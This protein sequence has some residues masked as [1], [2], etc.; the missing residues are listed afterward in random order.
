MSTILELDS[1]QEKLDI[2]WETL[3]NSSSQET[4]FEE[5]ALDDHQFSEQDVL[6]EN[7]ILEL[8]DSLESKDTLLQDDFPNSLMGEPDD[9]LGLNLDFLFEFDNPAFLHSFF[10]TLLFF[11]CLFIILSTLYITPSFQKSPISSVAEPKAT[12]SALSFKFEALGQGAGKA[13]DRTINYVF[14]YFQSEGF[15]Q[16][17]AEY[18][19]ILTRYICINIPS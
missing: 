5:K 9:R 18:S 12:A 16:K 13:V 15:H 4:P 17:V 7:E 2:N 10:F 19:N 3:S 1:I 14:D 8:N 11:I 6:A